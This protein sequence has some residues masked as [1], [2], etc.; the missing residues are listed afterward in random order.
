MKHIV[1]FDL[2]TDTQQAEILMVT[3]N[4]AFRTVPVAA[5]GRQVVTVDFGSLPSGTYSCHLVI[6]NNE[7]SRRDLIVP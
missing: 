6:D 2:P 1:P 5:N 3:N 7:V 4:Q